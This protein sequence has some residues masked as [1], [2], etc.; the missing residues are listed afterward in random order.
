M[1]L[2]T[3]CLGFHPGKS[4]EL[5]AR[6]GP[7]GQALGWLVGGAGVLIVGLPFRILRSEW[8]RI[9]QASS[10]LWVGPV[11][12]LR[13]AVMGVGLLYVGRGLTAGRD[14]LV[15]RGLN[16]SFGA[17]LAGLILFVIYD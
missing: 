3:S 10:P 11:V 16:L 6:P 8:D 14:A 7:F 1:R 13:Y 4:L 12:L 15:R 5:D 9:G 17:L 2:L